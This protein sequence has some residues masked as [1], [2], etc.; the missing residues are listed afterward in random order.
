M[1]TKYI[2]KTK[3]GWLLFLLLTPVLLRAES[4]QVTLTWDYPGFPTNLT[5]RVFGAT[6][7]GP[8]QFLMSV[9]T[10]KAV[11][12]FDRSLTNRWYVTAVLGGSS[13]SVPSNIVQTNPPPLPQPPPA[14]TNLRSV[15]VQGNRWDLDW[16]SSLLSATEVERSTFPGPFATIETVS[17][18]TQH[19]S[20]TAK[21]KINYA[22]RVRSVNLSGPS[23]YSNT[24]V[25]YSRN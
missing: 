6:N 15:R 14:P 23:P 3:I 13:E 11:F 16:S 4:A 2:M 17:P 25:I 9:A 20:V 22:L 7:A 10:N 24:N 8:F 19:T 21:P 12:A 1:E 18:G 5:F